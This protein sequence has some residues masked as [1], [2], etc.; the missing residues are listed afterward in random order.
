MALEIW[1]NALNTHL[2]MSDNAPLGPGG[3]KIYLSYKKF[4]NLRHILNLLHV[5]VS[6]E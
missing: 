1:K 5:V 6:G 2:D 4:H 3:T